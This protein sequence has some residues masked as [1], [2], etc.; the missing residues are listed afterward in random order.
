MQREFIVRIR[1]DS[2][3]DIRTDKDVTQHIKSVY[4]TNKGK[5]NPQIDEM[6]TEDSLIERMRIAMG[7][8]AF[9]PDW[10]KVK[11]TTA[12][13]PPKKMYRAKK[14]I[15]DLV[16]SPLP[17]LTQSEIMSYFEEVKTCPTCGKVK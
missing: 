1:M 8:P 17:P 11:G 7:K 2:D 4:N 14:N 10:G 16:Y 9:P 15:V 13:D 3:F 6:I 12:F 5:L